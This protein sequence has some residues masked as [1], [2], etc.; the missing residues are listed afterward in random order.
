MCRYAMIAYKSHYAC[1]D[2]RKTFK[3]KLLHDV[4][5]DEQ[6]TKDAKC[7]QCGALMANMG[8]DFEAPKMDNTK[9][10]NHI[11]NLYSVGITFHSC[12]CSGPGYI[13]NS[14]EKLIAYFND[15]K[16]KY[17]ENLEFWR[18]RVEPTNKLEQQKDYNRN[19]HH[20]STVSSNYKK[21][22]VTNQEGIKYW[23]DKIKALELKIE[24]IQ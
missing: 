2:C 14:T 5:R 16:L 20:L 12:G 15:I 8:L 7:P 4:D 10:W 22:M 21:Q 19:W 23:L 18:A 13:P 1:F 9:A 6:Q 17:F 24:M 11:K 3:R